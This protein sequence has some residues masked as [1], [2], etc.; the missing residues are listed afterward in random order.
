MKKARSA[1]LDGGGRALRKIV[2]LIALAVA[3]TVSVSM[4]VGFGTIGYRYETAIAT[5]RATH[6]AG[7]LSTFI[8]QHPQFWQYQK[9]RLS[10]L[11]DFGEGQDGSRNRILDN[12][13]R[14]VVAETSLST[15]FQLLGRAPILV[16]GAV[17]GYVESASPVDRLARE[18]GLVALFGLL[19]GGVTYVA[20][21][22]LPLRIID[23]TLKDLKT[24]SRL[25]QR[26]N[27]ALETQNQALQ[28]TKDALKNRS[29]QLIEAQL[30]GGIGDWSYRIGE[31]TIDWSAELF[32]LLRFDRE[33]Y[34]C[35]RDDIISRY[36]GDSAKRVLQ[37]QAD[38]VRTREV[39]T[40][41]V[42]FRRGDGTVGDF[43]VVSK[44]AI[45]SDGAL[46]GFK[47]TI[48]DITER[49][50]AEEQLQ[51]LAYY[52]PLTGLPNRSLFRRKAEDALERYLHGGGEAAVMLLD[53]DRFK[54][55]N[56]SLGHA[57]GDEL[58]DKVAHVISRVLGNRHLLAR[59]G[60]D[61]FGIIVTDALGRAEIEALARDIITAV[62]EPIALSRG[63]V[64]IGTSVGIAGIPRDGDTISD[65]LRNADLALYRA[66][67]AGRGRFQFFEEDMSTTVQHKLML[68]RDLRRAIT[69]NSGLSVHFQPQVDILSNKVVG[70]EALMRWTHPSL[71]NVSPDEFIPIAESSHLICD[72][73]LWILRES[74]KQAKAWIDAGETP[75]QVAVNVSASQIWHTDFV[76]DVIGVLRETALP[77][78]LLCLELTESLLVD[79]AEGRVRKVLMELKRA[80]VVLALDDFGTD[81][82]SLGYLVQLPFDKLKIDRIFI[83]GIADSDRVRNLLQGIVALGRG[84]RM[85]VV[86]EGV[87]RAEELDIIRT[88]GCDVVQGYIF[89][90]PSSAAG[91][92]AIAREF[93]ENALMNS[94][95][96][97][98]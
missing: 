22:L 94:K 52:D 30:L 79:H 13:G 2:N 77:P 35:D 20:F 55:V 95:L 93:E 38:I 26:K 80:G 73:G 11:V 28:A 57:A 44:A 43:V 41:D 66:K 76:N 12:A 83:N 3:L 51:K 65:L 14:M 67:E 70:F 16:S 45:D 87:E 63:E 23:R 17:V 33:S 29:D 27:E 91:A 1:E 82:S 92:L 53:L 39:Q 64:A 7:R 42:K 31:S 88:L 98:A 54:E 85:Q 37:A 71:G 36:V 21:R 48:Q 68:G 58:L 74:A 96:N 84:L 60:G 56:D 8:Y 78:H 34:S 46:I 50:Q 4:P 62:S 9:L 15:P 47:G 19:M 49:K 86:M 61:E 89:A 6:Y 10:E 5:S 40:I 69:E 90:R 81:Y 24:A 75:R 72:L 25:I 97:V 18:T 32:A 59:L